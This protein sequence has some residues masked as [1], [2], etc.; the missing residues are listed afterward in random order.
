M[1]VAAHGFDHDLMFQQT[2]AHL[3]RICAFLIDLVD[4][5]DHRH[6]CGLGMLNGFNRLRHQAIIGSHHQNDDVGYRSAALT[7]LRECFMARCIEERDDRAILRLHLI[8]ANMLRNAACFARY[9]IRT[10]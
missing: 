9:D 5:N 2:L 10:A 4:R 6:I 7:H 8:R 3:L 1:N